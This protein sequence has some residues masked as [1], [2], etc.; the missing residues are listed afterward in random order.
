MN[1]ETLKTL[2][3]EYKEKLLRLADHN[4]H[5]STLDPASVELTSEEFK[6]TAWAFR[7]SVK[8][9]DEIFNAKAG[10]DIEG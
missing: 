9:L 4:D 7:H 10:L 2:L 3:K 8:L 6:A 1:E 5:M